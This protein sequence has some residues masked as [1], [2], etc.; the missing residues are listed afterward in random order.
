MQ[1]NSWVEG[2]G[3]GGAPT[4]DGI[5]FN[6]LQGVYVNNS[7]DQALGTFNFP[8]GSSGANTYTLSL[9]SGLV[10]DA[11][12]GS[13]ISLRLFAADSSVS[14]LFDSR[15]GGSGS[16]FHP[17]ITIEATAVPE[18]GSLWLCL[19]ALA[20]VWLVRSIRRFRRPGH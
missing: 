9:S 11:L 19:V 18:P 16:A 15:T 6:S 5:S 17:D 4:S 8:G 1:N 2:T 12:S 3:T 10:A 13:D 7:L 14:Y 20:L